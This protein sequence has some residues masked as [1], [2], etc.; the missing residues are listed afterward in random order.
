MK[1]EDKETDLSVLCHTRNNKKDAV[2]YDKALILITIK[3]NR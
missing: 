3:A 2:Q 1:R